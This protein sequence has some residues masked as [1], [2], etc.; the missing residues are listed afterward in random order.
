MF[1]STHRNFKFLLAFM[2]VT[3]APIK[4]FA[5]DQAPK[6]S[7]IKKTGIKSLESF[8][9]I[10]EL[11]KI[12]LAYLDYYDVDREIID[13]KKTIRK[14]SCSPNGDQI[15]TVSEDAWNSEKQLTVYNIP[16]FSI[17]HQ[18]TFSMPQPR[19]G[20]SMTAI[21]SMSQLSY[22]TD[23]KFLVCSQSEVCPHSIT[24]SSKNFKP[25]HSEKLGLQAISGTHTV[26]ATTER[27]KTIAGW[28]AGVLV[29]P[30]GQF[31]HPEA[32]YVH[33]SFSK[34][35]QF[36]FCGAACTI[37]KRDANDGYKIIDQ[38]NCEDQNYISQ[39]AVTPDE[40]SIVISSCGGK[41]YVYNL[42][43]KKC[44]AQITP[45]RIPELFAGRL[46]DFCVS[47]DGETIPYIIESSKPKLMALVLHNIKTKEETILHEVQFTENYV[48]SS[49]SYSPNGIYLASIIG[50]KIQIRKNQALELQLAA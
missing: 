9:P 48:Q 10:P 13:N 14:V 18:S 24:W 29:T 46:V 3:H 19:A 45:Y 12:I 34:N 28:Y 4:L 32:P 37:E 30:A 16:H 50:N 5:M 38:F 33:I 1:A 17:M 49:V 31:T 26:G 11:Q 22:S 36:L 44:C 23:G 35:G 25:T 15:A 39:C 43:T 21:P 41:I 6:A 7:C 47:P 27:S 8:I 42:E 20:G 40:K 2:L